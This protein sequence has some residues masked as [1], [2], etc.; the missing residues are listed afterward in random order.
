MGGGAEKNVSGERGCLSGVSG[1]RAASKNSEL[2]STNKTCS[3]G[4]TLQAPAPQNSAN[5]TGYPSWGDLRPDTSPGGQ[6][7]YRFGAGARKLLGPGGGS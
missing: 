6:R 5:C 4:P 3:H 2:P 1:L 7:K